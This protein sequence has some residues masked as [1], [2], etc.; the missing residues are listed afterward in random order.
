MPSRE[1]L[2]ILVALGFIVI[3]ASYAVIY[4]LELNYYKKHRQELTELLYG[5]DPF[6]SKKKLYW[7]DQFIMFG[8]ISYGLIVA[9]R[10]KGNKRLPKQGLMVFAPKIMEKQNYA[11][12]AKEHPYL[13]K[14]LLM[15][16]LILML[17]MLEGGLVLLTTV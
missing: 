7:S 9:W 4:R 8:G 5:H 3:V 17:L 10:D 13:K 16:I 14:L 6:E 11:T 1:T 15:H 12:L 2:E